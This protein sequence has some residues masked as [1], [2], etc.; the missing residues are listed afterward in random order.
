MSLPFLGN[1]GNQL[2]GVS[3]PVK[4]KK[5]GKGEGEDEESELIHNSSD[6][7]L[8]EDGELASVSSTP[9]MKPVIT[10]RYVSGGQSGCMWG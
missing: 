4:R 7:E 5:K 2:D 3:K 8:E 10:D 9:P 6:E 1:Y